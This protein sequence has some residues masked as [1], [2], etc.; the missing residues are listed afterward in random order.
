MQFKE[1]FLNFV[2]KIKKISKKI[3]L[4]VVKLGTNI[5]GKYI[6]NQDD[7]KW[8]VLSFLKKHQRKIFIGVFL[9]G[10]IFFWSWYF[11]DRNVGLNEEQ[12]VKNTQEKKIIVTQEIES[13]K[14][15]DKKEFSKKDLGSFWLEIDTNEIKVKAPIINGTEDN[16]LD[17]GL[18]R[19]RTSAMPGENG[20]MVIS[21]H[22]WKFGGNPSYKAFEDLD[23]LEEGDKVKVYYDNKVFEYEIIGNGN[24]VSPN[25]KGGKEILKKYDQPMLTL[26]TCTP[27]RT[28]L[29]RLYYRAKFV[30]ELE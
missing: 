25:K 5:K 1:K 8:S 29:R 24:V 3:K 13:E 9:L 21:G 15:Q 26:Y 7:N 2:E 16:D 27:K 23:K 20:N 4:V 30:Q 17:Q 19:H 11:G 6:C 14:K 12:G 22:R 10:Y 28:S 18:G